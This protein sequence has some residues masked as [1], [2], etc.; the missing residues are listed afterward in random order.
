MEVL[1]ITPI[2]QDQNVFS[3]VSSLPCLLLVEHSLDDRV[4]EIDV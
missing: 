4:Y 1:V 3:S 2:L